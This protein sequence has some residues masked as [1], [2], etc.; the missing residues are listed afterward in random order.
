MQ[1]RMLTTSQPPWHKTKAPRPSRADRAAE[2]ADFKMWLADAVAELQREHNV[3]PSTIPMRVFL[4]VL[5]NSRVQQ[6]LLVI[7]PASWIASPPP[8]RA[9]EAFDATNNTFVMWRRVP[10]WQ[11]R[12]RGIA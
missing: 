6:V 7:A 12:T 2:Q 8:R 3:N 11:R 4:L 5:L 1:A 10:P 9:W